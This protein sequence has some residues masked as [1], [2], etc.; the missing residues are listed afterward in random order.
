MNIWMYI[1]GVLTILSG[2]CVVAVQKPLHCAMWLI[3]TFFMLAADYALLCAD[4]IAV[5]QVLVYAGAV[6]VLVVFVLMLLGPTAEAEG[7]VFK[8]KNGVALFLVCAFAALIGA[9]L[10][11]SRVVSSTNLFLPADVVGSIKPFGQ[12]IFTRYIYAFEL[13][14]V[15]IL[16]AAIGAVLLAKEPR[17]GLAPGRGLRAKHSQNAEIED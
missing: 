8:L 10:I 7:E 6:M 11:L 3:V 17:R 5:L 9:M 13:A 15:L 12:L 14:S 4:F 16:A 1:F 2:C